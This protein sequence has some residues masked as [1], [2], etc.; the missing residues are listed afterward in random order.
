MKF[1]VFYFLVMLSFFA[2]YGFGTIIRSA[3]YQDHPQQPWEC[4]NPIP[5]FERDI[6]D[7]I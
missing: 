3:F 1:I 2:G 4:V 5:C 6:R 7:S